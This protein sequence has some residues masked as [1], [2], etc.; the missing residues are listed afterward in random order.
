VGTLTGITSSGAVNITNTTASTSTATGALKCSGGVGIGGNVNIGGNIAAVNITGTLLTA[1]QPNIT[2]VGTLTGITSSGAVNITNTTASTSTATGALKC[3]GGVGIGGNVNIGGNIAAVN[4]TGTLLTAAQPNITSVGTLTNLAVS[5]TI[6]GTLATAA[7]PNITSVGTL[8]NLAVSGTITG[9]LATAAQPNITSLGTLTGL[10]SSGAVNITNTTASTS[11]ATGALIVSGGVG[12]AKKLYVGDAVYSVN[13]ISMNNLSVIQDNGSM[14][15]FRSGT[16]LGSWN[17]ISLVVMNT[18]ASTST[19]TGALVVSG[20]AGIAGNVNIGGNIAA[21]NITGTLLTA[22]QPNITSVGTLTGLTCSGVATITNTTASTSTSTGSLVVSGGVGIGGDVYVG[23]SSLY[24][25][26]NNN[27][28]LQNGTDFFIKNYGTGK[29]YFYNQ[30]TQS[31]YFNGISLR[32]NGEL[33]VGGNIVV[34][35]TTAS[36]STSTGALKV[37]GG[38][39]IAGNTYIGGDNFVSGMFQNPTLFTYNSTG[40]ITITSAGNNISSLITGNSTTQ[41]YSANVLVYTVAMPTYSTYSINMNIPIGLKWSSAQSF[42]QITPQL[43]AVYAYVYKDGVLWATPTI[44]NNNTL[45]TQKIIDVAG[46]NWSFECYWDNASF[47]FTPDFQNYTSTYTVY[48]RTYTNY[49]SNSLLNINHYSI[50]NETNLQ[51]FTNT[52]FRSGYSYN[53]GYSATSGTSS[54]YTLSNSRTGDLQTG[55]IYTNG[56][57]TTNVSSQNSLFL[58]NIISSTNSIFMAGNVGSG[59]Y[60]TLSQSGDNGLFWN[61]NG[62]G[63]PTNGL[64]LGGWNAT[65]GVRID[66]NGNMNVSGNISYNGTT[67]PTKINNSYRITSNPNYQ[68]PTDYGC[69]ILISIGTGTSVAITGNIYLPPVASSAGVNVNI[70]WVKVSTTNCY[71]NVYSGNGTVII[72]NSTVFYSRIVNNNNTYACVKIMSDGTYWYVISETNL[73]YS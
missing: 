11:T 50:F 32:V 72:R 33:D 70:V 2:S 63:T 73:T 23:G 55:N 49:G 27:V 51:L 28:I 1:A 4:I 35:S 66:N 13:G 31:G 26:S 47:S 20:G 29:L 15:F 7:Q 45:G 65:G 43:N 36:T 5:G 67:L 64:V 59:G 22:A 68:I 62:G 41:Y 53:S 19:V 40:S 6:T 9:T 48:M 42:L 38:V 52:S 16:Q 57:L 14:A 21:V 46:A 60:N 71:L 34:N 56:C 3:S 61:N 10:T 58:K 24:I 44:T 17:I 69:N 30:G 12:I 18:T 39:G 25:G 54:Y 8:T 37:S